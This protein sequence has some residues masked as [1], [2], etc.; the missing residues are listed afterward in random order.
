[1]ELDQKR[2]KGLEGGKENDNS[3]TI[4]ST[5]C[6]RPIKKQPTRVELRSRKLYGKKKATIQSASRYLIEADKNSSVG[7]PELLAVA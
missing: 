4:S 7:E 1:M 5:L 3:N 2:R 6:Y